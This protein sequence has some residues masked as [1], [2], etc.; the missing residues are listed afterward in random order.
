MQ[1]HKLR[2][3]GLEQSLELSI[4]H[5]SRVSHTALLIPSSQ[6][7]RKAPSFPAPQH[8]ASS[9]HA[10]LTIYGMNSCIFLCSFVPQPLSKQIANTMRSQLVSAYFNSATVPHTLKKKKST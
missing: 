6:G 2:T 8:L 5:H 7:F 1:P 3:P 9:F 10:E 4:I